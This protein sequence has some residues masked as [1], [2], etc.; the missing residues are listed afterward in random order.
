MVCVR[1]EET[2][3]LLKKRVAKSVVHDGSRKTQ[4]LWT[5]TKATARVP[6]FLLNDVSLIRDVNTIE[7]LSDILPLNE[8]DMMDHSSALGDELNIGPLD[9][10]LILNVSGAIAGDIAVHFDATNT[11][12]AQKVSDFARLF[13]ISAGDVDGE[14]SVDETKLV[15]EAD[16]GSG[17]HVLYHGTDSVNFGGVLAG[18]VPDI[19]A[20]LAV[21]E[22]SDVHAGLDSA[23]QGAAGAGDGYLAGLESYLDWR[24]GRK[25]ETTRERQ[26]T[27]IEVASREGNM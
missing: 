2:A 4:L 15:S 24:R 16:C 13:V 23:L 5:K 12:L 11:L 20:D 26:R 8:T 22:T 17:D 1:R 10:K 9:N 3:P 27:Q 6:L 7:E 25:K 19:N 21:F 14:M 18:T